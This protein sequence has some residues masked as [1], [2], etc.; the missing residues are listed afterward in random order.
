MVKAVLSRAAA[1]DK[2]APAYLFSGTRGVGKTTIARIFAK[3]LNCVHAPAAAP[4]NQCEQCRKITQ[5]IHVD[6]TE[7][8]GASNNSVED[9]RALREKIGYAPM[10][11]R[12]KVFIIDEA[13]M[14]SRS[15]FNA[16]LKTLEEP[17]AR[18]VFIF[19]TTEA[20]KFPVTIVSR[21][22]HFIFRHLPESAIISHLTGVLEKEG[23]PFEEG[24]VR[25]I[26]KRAAGSV[27]DSMS[28]LDQT[29]AL[30]GASLTQESAREVLGL[31]GQEMFVSLLDALAAQDCANVSLLL[32][33]LLDQG[34]DIGFFL[35]ELANIWRMLFLIR[36]SGDKALPVLELPDDEAR[37]WKEQAPR[38]SLPHIHAA[39][40]MVLDTQ[41]RVIQSP[42]PAAALELLL[43]HLALLPRLLPL[44]RL[45]DATAQG[46]AA[47]AG[48]AAPA[49]TNGAA[50]GRGAN[51]SSGIT[52]TAPAM[53]RHSGAAPVQAVNRQVSD[54]PA[55]HAAAPNAPREGESRATPRTGR[56]DGEDKADPVPARLRPADTPPSGC[57]APEGPPAAPQTATAFEGQPAT[58]H[59]SE[60]LAVLQKDAAP[61]TE[62]SAAAQANRPPAP[63]ANTADISSA[64]E[65]VLPPELRSW[66]DF[67]AFC[68]RE[69]EQGR[70]MPLPMPML[71]QASASFTT[72]GCSIMPTT[73]TLGNLLERNSEDLARLMSAYCGG[74]MT[75]SVGA[76]AR[77]R[78]TEAQL[79]EVFKTR[80]EVQRCCEVLDAKFIHC[81]PP[82]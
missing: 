71:P 45:P 53:P 81:Q 29:L 40:Q 3:A 44:D 24:A 72:A 13:H 46:G 59:G 11:G 64:E 57:T 77:Q 14:L 31:A 60:P 82:E 2:V 55:P 4:C 20:H 6:V 79:I 74:T 48:A 70:P 66:A 1:E 52:G 76:P 65:P 5:G 69:Q 9:A 8:D 35:R 17:P 12:Y 56:Q 39:W 27:R 36:Q 19:A 26:A 75:V 50:G 38:F 30:G 42:E 34:V 10:E 25:L 22:Q 43:L 37:V 47:P 7:I 58:A 51:G 21:C 63:V 16:L 18:V 41:R 23:M 54:T 33:R 32:R 78:K 62:R 28:L 67:C 68:A 49:G 80:E 73:Q 15:A 61:D